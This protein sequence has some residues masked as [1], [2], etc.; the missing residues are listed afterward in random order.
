ML[1]AAG[2]ALLVPVIACCTARVSPDGKRLSAVRSRNGERCV[3]AV[4]SHASYA[5][6]LSAMPRIIGVI[7]LQP[8]DVRSCAIVAALQPLVAFA[9]TTKSA[10]MPFVASATMLAQLTAFRSAGVR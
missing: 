3:S 2:P 10:V 5:P 4:A 9:F 6:V 8:L 1:P 7:W